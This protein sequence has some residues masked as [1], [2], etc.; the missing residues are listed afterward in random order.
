MDHPLWRRDEQRERK[1]QALQC[2]QNEVSRISDLAS[3]STFV[4]QRQ[5]YRRPNQ[6]SKFAK[7]EP[8]ASELATVMDICVSQRNCAFESPQS[9]GSDAACSTTNKDKPLHSIAIVHVYREL[10]LTEAFTPCETYKALRCVEH[11]QMCSV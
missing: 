10:D 8:D 6:P 1:A 2:N 9:R 3:L 5:L 11:I 7:A 4:V